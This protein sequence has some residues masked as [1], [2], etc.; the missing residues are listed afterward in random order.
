MPE[1]TSI[2]DRDS[3]TCEPYDAV[4]KDIAVE[5][6]EDLRFTPVNECFYRN[7]EID[8]NITLGMTYIHYIPTKH[9]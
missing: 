1:S 3:T 8:V 9:F 6:I 4:N 7:G 5:H 2:N